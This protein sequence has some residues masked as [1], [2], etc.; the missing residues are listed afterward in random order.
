MPE[1][2]PRKTKKMDFRPRGEIF[3]SPCDWRDQF[4]YFLL[5]DRFNDG[6]ERPP[7][8]SG[9]AADRED[10]DRESWQGGNLRGVVEKLDYIRCLG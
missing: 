9:M 10:R 4:V 2:K 7:Y 8:S 5:L 3:P 1:A 6:K